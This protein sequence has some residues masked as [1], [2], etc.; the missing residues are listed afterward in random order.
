MGT[1]RSIMEIFI[2][3]YDMEQYQQNKHQRLNKNQEAKNNNLE[4][5]PA[6]TNNPQDNQK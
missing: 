1:D 5:S 3:K 6:S 2:D 4:S